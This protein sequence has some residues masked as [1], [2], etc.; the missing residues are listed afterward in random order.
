M[1]G[2]V[3]LPPKSNLFYN[4]T[5]LDKT[6]E[7]LKQN[8]FLWKERKARYSGSNDYCKEH[9][10]YNKDK[11]SLHEVGCKCYNCE[12]CRCKKKYDLLK[13]PVILK[14]EKQEKKYS[15]E[16]KRRNA[17]V[18]QYNKSWKGKIFGE[19]HFSKPLNTGNLV[20][21]IVTHNHTQIV[22]K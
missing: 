15:A 4:I 11:D 1:L 9:F 13:C 14:A 10:L 16:R 6:L 3:I 20:L 8:E 2:G 17:M 7:H 21:E 12:R 18:E 5:L 19:R 22:L